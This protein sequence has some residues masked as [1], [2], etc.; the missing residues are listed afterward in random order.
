MIRSIA[1][2][3]YFGVFPV[4]TA[5]VKTNVVTGDSGPTDANNATVTTSVLTG[6]LQRRLRSKVV[7]K[8]NDGC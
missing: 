1:G 7:P 6:A 3:F 5:V 4:G 8:G 2:L